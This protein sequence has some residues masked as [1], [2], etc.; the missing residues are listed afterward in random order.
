MA[1]PWKPSGLIT[2][3]HTCARDDSSTV[4]AM[5]MHL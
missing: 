4:D 1:L 5:D 3:R 2:L